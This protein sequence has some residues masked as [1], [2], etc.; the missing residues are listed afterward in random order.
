MSDKKHDL[1]ANLEFFYS[2][3]GLGHCR[4]ILTSEELSLSGEGDLPNF[5]LSYTELSGVFQILNC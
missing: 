3:T 2:H 1:Y 5:D 4:A